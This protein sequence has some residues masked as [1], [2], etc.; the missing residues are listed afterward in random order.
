ML[1]VNTACVHIRLNAELL[2]GNSTFMA[3]FFLDNLWLGKKYLKKF[4]LTDIRH[5]TQLKMDQFTKL[6]LKKFVQASYFTNRSWIRLFFSWFRKIYCRSYEITSDT[7]IIPFCFT[8]I[9]I[10]LYLQVFSSKCGIKLI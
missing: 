8:Y 9:C 10:C 1:H 6:R 5:I 2:E 3:I 4:Q 7:K